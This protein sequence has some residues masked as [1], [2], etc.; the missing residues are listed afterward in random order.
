MPLYGY[1][2]KQCGAGFTLLLSFSQK[3]KAQCPR[4]KAKDLEEDYSGYGSKPVAPGS[5]SKFT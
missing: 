5:A 3:D 1:K 2:C 4:C